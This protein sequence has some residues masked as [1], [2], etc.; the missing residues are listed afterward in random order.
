M[1][2]LLKV[3]VYII[4]STSTVELPIKDP[5]RGGYNR[6]KL[7]TKDMLESQMFISPYLLSIHF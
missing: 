1:Y 4:T 3:Y 7:S 5:P 2:I 6:N